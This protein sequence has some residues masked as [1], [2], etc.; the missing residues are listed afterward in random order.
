MKIS[1]LF[2][3]IEF[4]WFF[5][6]IVAI[7]IAVYETIKNGFQHSYMFFIIAGIAIVMF[8]IRRTIRKIRE[9]QEQDNHA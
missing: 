4:L 7:A 3:G 5:L 6:A 2:Y 1:K 9:Q 8:F